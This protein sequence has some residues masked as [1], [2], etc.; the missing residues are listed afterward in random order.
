MAVFKM[1]CQCQECWYH[2]QRHIPH[3]FL[4]TSPFLFT[5]LIMEVY[6]HSPSI[7]TNSVMAAATPTK[8]ATITETSSTNE[9]AKLMKTSRSNRSAWKASLTRMIDS[10]RRIAPTTTNNEQ[11]EPLKKQPITQMMKQRALYYLEKKP[12]TT[13]VADNSS[14]PVPEEE[15]AATATTSLD[16]SVTKHQQHGQQQLR[17][18]MAWLGRSFQRLHTAQKSKDLLRAAFK[19][20]K[21]LPALSHS[22]A[23]SIAADNISVKEQKQHDDES[24]GRPAFDHERTITAHIE[25]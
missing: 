9:P 13:I 5:H 12:W 1:I 17:N 15:E 7:E 8:P 25:R 19:R 14:S 22:T 10:Q 20:N 16:T 3:L 23:S 11:H 2:I 6:F 4:L 21:S 24:T 18:A